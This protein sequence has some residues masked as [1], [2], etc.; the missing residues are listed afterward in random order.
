MF[1]LLLFMGASLNSAHA[2]LLTPSTSTPLPGTTFAAEP[3]LGGTVLVDDLVDFSFAAYGGTVFGT[4]QVRV[5]E[6]VD[7]TIDFYWRVKNN[8]E[9][10]GAIGSF[11]IGDFL[12][13]SYNANYRIDGLGDDAPDSAYLFSAP[14]EGY[15]NF[16]F[17][18]GLLA[19]SSS[20]FFFLDTN[21][22]A[23]AKTAFYDLTNIGQTQ[24]SSSYSGY[25][26]VYDV[27]APASL[28]LMGLGLVALGVRRRRLQTTQ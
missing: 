26:P 7:N 23:Y 13:P 19:G 20:N 21:A 11:R 18:D 4:V 25:A 15:V 6:A 17:A 16:N 14:Y 10:S 24:I 5:V 9:S 12:T 28:G 3:Q 8:I 2:V 27:P 22:T 1:A